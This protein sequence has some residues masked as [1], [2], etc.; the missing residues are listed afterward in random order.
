MKGY[1]GLYEWCGKTGQVRSVD[2]YVKKWDGERITRGQILK[3]NK[4]GNY[5]VVTL[6]RDSKKEYF[7]LHRL[8]ATNGIPNPDNKPQIDHIDGDPSNNCIWNLRWSTV[9]ENAN[10]PITRKRKSEARK[11]IEFSDEWKRHIAEGHIGKKHTEEHKRKIS[12]SCKNKK[13]NSRM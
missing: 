10:N 12:V 3:P 4:R 11:G 1:E 9:S 8:I 13:K 5:Y 6:S 2:R 7:L